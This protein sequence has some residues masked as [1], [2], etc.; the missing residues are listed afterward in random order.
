MHC[1]LIFTCFLCMVL[2]FKGSLHFSSHS[3]RKNWK[4]INAHKGDREVGD[5]RE[6]V[7]EKE[8]KERR[9]TLCSV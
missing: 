3:E 9:E 1:M 5:G 4:G 6:T 2:K 8:K 7:K